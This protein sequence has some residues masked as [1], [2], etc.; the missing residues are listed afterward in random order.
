MIFLRLGGGGARRG[1]LVGFLAIGAGLVILVSGLALLAILA[2]ALGAIGMVVLMYRQLRGRSRSGSIRSRGAMPM[3]IEPDFE[4][5]P[6]PV[7]AAD[8]P[9]P[10][11]PDPLAERGPQGP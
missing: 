2:L 7:P 4:I 5:L 6:S 3:E 11:I 10:Q 8:D 9:H 1:S